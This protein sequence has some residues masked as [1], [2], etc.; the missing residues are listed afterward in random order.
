M[1]ERSPSLI[2]VQR[3]IAFKCPAAISESCTGVY[4]TAQ[5][6]V[7]AIENELY[8]SRK[9]TFDFFRRCIDTLEKHQWGNMRRPPEQQEPDPVA[10]RVIKRS[11]HVVAYHIEEFRVENYR[12]VVH[13]VRIGATRSNTTEGVHTALIADMLAKINARFPYKQEVDRYVQ[14]DT[15]LLRV[16]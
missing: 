6:S 13:I 16:E 15:T 4:R 3:G 10:V 14:N 9:L 8:G 7:L 5:N 12:E 11:G 1:P 2:W